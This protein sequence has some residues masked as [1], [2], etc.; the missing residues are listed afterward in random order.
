MPISSKIFLAAAGALLVMN[1]ITF[2]V[3]KTVS[4][5]IIHRGEEQK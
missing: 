1:L 2:I 3:Y 4:R 5:H